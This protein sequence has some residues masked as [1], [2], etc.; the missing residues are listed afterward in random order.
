MATYTQFYASNVSWNKKDWSTKLWSEA[1]PYYIFFSLFF[2]Q[3]ISETRQD[4]DAKCNSLEIKLGSETCNYI[5]QAVSLSAYLSVWLHHWWIVFYA[6]IPTCPFNIS[7]PRNPSIN[8]FMQPK[9]CYPRIWNCG[10]FSASLRLPRS[11]NQTPDQSIFE[12][13]PTE[14]FTFSALRKP[15]IRVSEQQKVDLSRD[16]EALKLWNVRSGFKLDLREFAVFIQCN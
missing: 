7:E 16:Y 13:I 12:N 14:H 11:S 10:R 15:S 4:F 6:S 5:W 8:N 9:N 3:S 2:M 1:L